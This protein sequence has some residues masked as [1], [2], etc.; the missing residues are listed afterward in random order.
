MKEQTATTREET[1]PAILL[2]VSNSFARYLLV[3][4][5]VGVLGVA[6]RELIGVLL[7]RDTPFYYGI[8]VVTIYALCVLLSFALHQVITFRGALSLIQWRNLLRFLLVAA[9]SGCCTGI[10]AIAIRYAPGFERLLEPYGAMV[11]FIAASVLVSAISYSLNAKYVF[12]TRN[13]LER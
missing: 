8:S 12:A 9:F 5:F 7:P 4:G 13:H 3:G 11:A 2:G 1:G 10:A 6:G